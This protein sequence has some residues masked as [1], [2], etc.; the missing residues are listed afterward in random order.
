MC[1]FMGRW[2]NSVTYKALSTVDLKID[3]SCQRVQQEC[4]CSDGCMAEKGCGTR[5]WAAQRALKAV[6]HVLANTLCVRKAFEDICRGPA[7]LASCLLWRIHV[8]GYR[9]LIGRGPIQGQQT[10]ERSYVEFSYDK[11]WDGV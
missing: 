10:T 9:F 11:P 1:R 8:R 2:R 5:F 4:C 3:V 6:C 7:Q